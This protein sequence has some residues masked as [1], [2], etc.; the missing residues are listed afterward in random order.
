MEQ[1]IEFVVRALQRESTIKGLCEEYGISRVTGYHWLRRYRETGTFLSLRDR[2]R[3]P[4]YSPGRTPEEQEERVI[5]LRRRYGWGARKLKVLLEREGI[6]LSERTINR[7]LSRRGEIRKEDRH[8]PALSRFERSRPNELWQVDFKGEYKLESGGCCYPL[9]IIDDQSRYCVGLYSLR[10]PRYEGV[11][12]R[13][14]E[15]FEQYGV[16]EGMLFDHGTPWW[17][18]ANVLGL[19]RLAVDLIEQGV[20]LHWSGIAHPQTQGKVERF[21][22]TLAAAL[23]HRGGPPQAFGQW[24]EL[25]DAIRQEYNHVRPHEALDMQVPADRYRESSRRLQGEPGAWKYPPGWQLQKVRRSG[26]FS[27][28]GHQ[29]FVSNALEG[30]QVG[31]LEVDARLLVRYR[32]K[33]L[34]EVDLESKRV[35]SWIRSPHQNTSQL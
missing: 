32:H 4:R 10:R 1:R 2:S 23:R 11:R 33:Y 16:P 5:E 6:G 31:V 15:T 20:R 28:K 14:W 8:R 18:T 13:L 12:A 35:H 30:R 26:Q 27:W 25:L 3:R 21:F 17:G 29:Y 22:G 24:K 34:C 9:G 7:V 19:T